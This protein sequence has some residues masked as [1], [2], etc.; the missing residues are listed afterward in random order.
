V[1]RLGV[2]IHPRV[3]LV[4]QLLG[5]RGY[6]T[7]GI[8]GQY[9]CHRV[10]GFDRGFDTYDDTFAEEIQLGVRPDLSGGHFHPEAERRAEDLVDA[11]NTWLDRSRGRPFF[12]WLHFMDPH[13]GYA[14]PSPFDTMFDAPPPHLGR[15]IFG[16]RLPLERI[17]PQALVGDRTD[18]GF[19]LNRYDGEIRYLDSQL[20][21]LL[22]GLHRRDLYD[23][24]LI[25]LT[26]DH[27]EYM[28]ESSTR[29]SVFNHGDT[30]YESEVRAPLVVKLPGQVAG[31]TRHPAAV[32]TVDVVPT[33][34]PDAAGLEGR[35]FPRIGATGRAQ[36]I[37][38]PKQNGIF[39]VRQG[40]HKVVVRTGRRTG[41]VIAALRRGRGVAVSA[42]LYDLAA[43]PW[44][45]SPS[46][47]GPELASALEQ[48]AHWLVEPATL[49]LSEPEGAPSLSRETA[50]RLRA[51]G[52]L[53]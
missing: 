18:Y 11:A 3:R 5:E 50:E 37:Q 4:S 40:R 31:G 25:V 33:L 28:G 21:R 13:P 10:F 30:A 12:M 8:C 9:N 15:S 17:H 38:L 23:D 41:E 6:A 42:E 14:P 49:E 52:Y 45:R 32:S 35:P 27:G 29:D 43:D 16:T 48:L 24:T 22:E 47:S 7:V 46:S 1:L 2:P 39:A 44:E 34:L 53:P 26:S 19:Y 51:L 20:G 36:M